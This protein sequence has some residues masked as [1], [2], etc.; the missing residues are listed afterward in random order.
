MHNAFFTWASL[1][2]IAGAVTATVLLTQLVKGIG[3]LAP[4]P[5]RALSYCIA[6]LMLSASTLITRGVGWQAANIAPAHAAVVALA[7][8][9]IY[10]GLSAL[11]KRR[12]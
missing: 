10:D 4:V 5:A 11:E 8:N 2:T 6:L 7:A 9:G 3:P 12:G 1:A